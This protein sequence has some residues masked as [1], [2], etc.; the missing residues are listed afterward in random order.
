METDPTRMCELLVGLPDVSVLGVDDEVNGF[1]LHLHRVERRAAGVCA[2]W[3]AGPD[4]GPHGGRVGRPAVFRAADPS[5]LAQVPLEVRRAVVS[6]GV[7]DRG[8]PSASVPPA[9][10]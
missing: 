3:R 5:H 9:W 1:L 6:D 4:E 10:R 7:V 8:G 2:L